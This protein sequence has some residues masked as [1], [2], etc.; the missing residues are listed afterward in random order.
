MTQPM[1]TK[2]SDIIPWPTVSV[3]T[4]CRN[5]LPLLRKTVESVVSQTFPDIEYVVI[6]GSSTDGTLEYVK[7]LGNKVDVFIS[8]PDNGIYD[9]MNKG[10]AHS[11]GEWIIFMNAGDTFYADDTVAQVF[12]GEDY[13]GYGVVY[14]DVAKKVGDAGDLVVK[15]ASA[16]HNSH[17]MFFCHQSAFY[18]REELEHTLFDTRHRMSADIHQ[19]KRLYNRGVKFR[20]L[21]IPVAVFD[22]SGVSNIRRSSGL[23]DNI[24]VVNELDPFLTRLK[25][26]PKLYIPYLICRLRHK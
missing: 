19:V 11:H 24:S 16:P 13:S 23:R 5:A 18:R 25:L 17:R 20:Q 4:V 6:D 26:L 8:E 7:S 2:Q 3:V 10:I 12:G 15:K 21:D 14:G 1:M 22:T 9:A